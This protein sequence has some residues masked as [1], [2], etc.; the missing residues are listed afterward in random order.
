MQRVV[1]LTAYED[2][3]GLL[4]AESKVKQEFHILLRK[5]VTGLQQ[6]QQVSD[7]ELK[8]I[9]QDRGVAEFR[10]LARVLLL[11]GLLRKAELQ[12]LL[13]QHRASVRQRRTGGGH[14]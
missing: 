9:L 4:F 8:Q 2:Q 7:G 11:Q 6:R 10:Q 14:A 12:D 3:H 13:Q 5:V 1:G